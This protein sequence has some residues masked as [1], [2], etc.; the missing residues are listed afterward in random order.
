MF[1]V[2]SRPPDWARPQPRRWWVDSEVARGLPLGVEVDAD[3]E[4]GRA[5]RVRERLAHA[6]LDPVPVDLAHRE[7]LRVEPAEQL[8]LAVAERPHADQR[9]AARLGGEPLASISFAA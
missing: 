4:E 7:H 5:R 8:A 6:G 9:A 3:V 1:Q 2:E